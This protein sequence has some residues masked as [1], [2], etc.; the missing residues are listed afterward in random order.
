MKSSAITKNE[1]FE[2][3][4]L[5]NIKRKSVFVDQVQFYNTVPLFSWIDINPTELCN[6]RCDFC[7]RADSNIYPNQNLNMSVQLAQKINAELNALHYKGGVVLSGYGEPMLHP[8]IEQLVK[9]L[10]KN[11]HLEMVTNGDKLSSEIIKTLFENGLN[12]MIISMYDG[13]HQVDFFTKMFKKAN[14]SSDSYV[15]RDRWYDIDEDYGV[16]LTNRAGA[17]TSGYQDKIDQFQQCFYPFYSMMLDWNGDVMLCVQD[18]NKKIKMGTIQNQ[19][20]LEVW[21][22]QNFE[23][24]RKVLHQGK[25]II[26]PCSNCNTRGTLHGKYHIEAWENLT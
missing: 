12:M 7:P 15:L 19:S 13:P 17:T 1:I 8:N 20:L 25:R 9:E 3:T 23:K 4:I 21:Q 11:V 14:I 5:K 2:Q 6:R 16:K 10:G 22:S 26:A 24:F 18:W